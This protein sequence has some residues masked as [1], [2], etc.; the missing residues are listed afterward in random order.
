MTFDSFGSTM[1]TD[2]I[3]SSGMC[4]DVYIII[5]H[6]SVRNLNPNWPSFLSAPVGT[7]ST[8]QA[9]PAGILL[10]THS[11]SIGC[12]WGPWRNPFIRFS[13]LVLQRV[14]D[15]FCPYG[16]NCTCFK[17]SLSCFSFNVTTGINVLFCLLFISLNISL[18]LF[19]CVTCSMFQHF[20]FSNSFVV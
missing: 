12:I 16:H 1:K 20:E 3:T 10:R 9:F 14:F 5:L 2:V 15:T 17:E 6:R 8:P 13:P 18:V 4:V 7:L 19:C 11:T